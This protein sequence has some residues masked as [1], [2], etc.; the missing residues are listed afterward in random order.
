[1]VK[2]TRNN[3]NFSQTNATCITFEGYFQLHNVT[4]NYV[5]QKLKSITRL[6]TANLVD[7]TS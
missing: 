5:E 3:Y 1:M 7:E 2:E 6:V 4:V